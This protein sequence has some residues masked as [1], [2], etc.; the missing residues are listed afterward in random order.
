VKHE[1]HA[2]HHPLEAHPV[3]HITDDELQSIIVEVNPHVVLLLLVSR[4]N[5]DAPGMVLDQSRYH[6]GAE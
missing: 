5:H 4:E 6:R 3:A 1:V 2:F